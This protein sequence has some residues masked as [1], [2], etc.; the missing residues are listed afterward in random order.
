MNT[1]LVPYAQDIKTTTAV[2][3]AACAALTG[4]APTNTVEIVPT[5]TKQSAVVSITAAPRATVT[6]SSL[7]LFISKD[8]GATKRLIRSVKMAALTVA[9]TAE[10]TTTTFST[11]S[12]T[13]P[14]LM[15]VGDSLWGGNQV[16]LASGVV[17]NVARQEY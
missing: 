11:I 13:T 14:L 2:T 16:A 1:F 3:T 4:D 17:W 10:I 7:L 6:D 15:E 5:L 12:L 9:A 8:G